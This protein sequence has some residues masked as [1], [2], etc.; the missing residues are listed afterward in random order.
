VRSISVAAQVS[1]RAIS[2]DAT[3]DRAGSTT[4]KSDLALIARSLF[5][6]AIQP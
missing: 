4:K 1:R 6:V 5:S 2:S 3:L